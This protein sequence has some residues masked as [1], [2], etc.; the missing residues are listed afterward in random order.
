MEQ[1]TTK[2]MKAK[3]Y[4]RAGK[5]EAVSYIQR[6]KSVKGDERKAVV[7][8]QK[9]KIKDWKSGLKALEKKERKLQKKAHK[10]YK[11]RMALPRT[12]AVWV[13]VL[14]IIGMIGNAVSPIVTNLSHIMGQKYT[15]QTAEAQAAR[16]AG[17]AFSTDISDEGIILLKNENDLLPLNNKKVN[18]F[19]D[20]AYNF[21]YSGG[22]SGAVDLR[23]CVT[24]F[25][26]L[27]MAG[28]EYN[29][30]LDAMYR[31]MGYDAEASG[32]N[33]IVAMLLS[34]LVGTET[35]DINSNEYLTADVLANAKAYSDQAI[36][37]LSNDVVESSD[38]S[39]EALKLTENRKELI[40]TVA[41]NFE[42]VIVIVN[43]GNAT[44]LGIVDE[45]DSIEAV[46]WTGIPGTQG[47]I[48]LGKVLSGAINPSGRLVDTYAYDVSS[49]PASENFASYKYDN[50]N[51]MAFI[52]YE[53]GI[54]VGYRYY[55]TRYAGDEA[56]YRKA[57]QYPFGHGLSY[58][59]FAWETVSFTVENETVTWEVKVT[60]TGSL[61]GKDVVQL[62]FSAPYI[63]G[64]IEKSAIELATYGKTVLL[65]PG[66]SEILILSFPVRDLS[67]YDMINEEAYV[68][69]AGTYEIK[70]ARNVHDIV[71]VQTYEVA[72]KVVYNTDEVTGVAIENRFDYAAGDLTY[73]SR[74]DWAGTYPTDNDTNYT[75]S[76]ELLAAVDAYKNPAPSGEAVPVTD[77]DNGIKLA[78]LRGLAYDDPKWE[79]F[80]DQFTYDELN[81][82]FS[83]GGW[84]S[85]AIDRLGIPSSRMLDGPAGINS[86][87]VPVSAAAYPTEMMV[88]STWNDDLAY[89]LGSYIGAEAVAYDVQV[90]YAPAMNL[91]RT[92]QGGRNFEY[93]SEEPVLSGMMAASTIRGA[94]EQGVIVTIKH[95]ILN[96]EETNAR[97]GIYCWT[98]EQAF[99]ELYLRPFELSVKDGGAH[100]AMSAFT[101][102]GYKWSGANPELLQDVLRG[103]WGF[104]GFVTTDAGMPGGFMDAGLA[105]RNGNDL[106]LDMGL[107]GAAKAVDTAYKA[108]PAGVLMGLRDCAHNLLY[109]LLNYTAVVK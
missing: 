47:C 15:D 91:H 30:E 100:G 34:F 37:V 28:I 23:N 89:Q 8:E 48:S 2:V 71:E 42:H 36:V 57:V 78:D 54:Y 39:L 65:P 14:L 58:T 59:D 7:K 52:N 12:V 77:A 96:N 83:D 33:N 69:D 109:S 29:P 93:Y 46:V 13:V 38:A 99:R 51:G 74:N 44:E 95:F 17:E 62:Y 107:A 92:A 25:K 90:W 86:M 68:L 85:N 102:I 67:S 80:L 21:K 72:E 27:E 24:L 105:C 22:G 70:L 32:T 103:E 53:E 101:H 40:R 26:G 94:Q 45:Y 79:Q 5:A 10:A 88:A 11:K 4:K 18:I 9:Q 73:L 87:Y 35:K 3:D 56:G 31:G 106:M 55:E 98:N 16:A 1:E 60:N 108:D 82:L 61:A 49:A 84:H 64:G 43:V 63:P 50:M 104:T 19:G 76:S 6:K 75:A 97:S 66:E 20:D 41:E 81:M